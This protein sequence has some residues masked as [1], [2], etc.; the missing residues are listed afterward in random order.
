MAE[1][2]PIVIF[3]STEALPALE[4]RT[5]PGAGGVVAHVDRIRRKRKGHA[6]A[7]LRE[8]VAALSTILCSTAVISLAT[9]SLS[10]FDKER[11]GPHPSPCRSFALM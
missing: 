8:N 3:A 6:R 11:T 1:E 4:M 10:F 7:W 9:P 2:Q 5:M